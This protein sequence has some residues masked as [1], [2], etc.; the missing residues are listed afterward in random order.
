MEI[1]K[2]RLFLNIYFHG[3]VHLCLISLCWLTNPHLY[4]LI[5][6]YIT[7]MRQWQRHTVMCI[8]WKWL[9][10]RIWYIGKSGLHPTILFRKPTLVYR[11]IFSKGLFCEQNCIFKRDCLMIFAFF[12]ISPHLNNYHSLC[13]KTVCSKQQS[14][15]FPSKMVGQPIT[16]SSFPA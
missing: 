8:P 16:T 7:V 13:S 12:H 4:W 5:H 10:T 15:L 2:D 11:E 3:V 14:T 9:W 6:K 1:Y